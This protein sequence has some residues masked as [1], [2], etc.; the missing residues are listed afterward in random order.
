M[1]RSVIFADVSLLLV[2][3]VWGTTFVLVQNA[4]AFLEPFS[5][6]GVRFLMAAFLL[7]GW[8]VIFEREQLKKINKKLLI[9]GIIMGLF[10]F[11]GYAFQTIGLLHTTSSKAGFIT[12]L[13]V[14]MVPVFSFMLLKIKPGFNAIIGVSIA[15]AGLY[16]LTMTD[17]V[18]LNI[19]DAYV[20]ICAV[21][22]AL[23]IIFTGKYSSKYP[24]LL[25][26]VIQ[27]GTVALLSGIFAFFTENWQQAFETG[28]LFKTNVVT[29]LIVTSLFATALAFFAQTA[30]QKF[31]TPTRV[32]LIFAME[33]VFA[34]AAGFMWANERLSFS[35]LTGCLLIFAG[36][37]FA[38]IPAKKTLSIF[39]R[40]TA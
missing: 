26:T 33:P 24:A 25:L 30:F 4:I 39:R 6:N 36:M 10:L 12:G 15:T 3:F 9:S 32:A 14:V 11:I 35:A 19:G 1:N 7:G 16:L 22:F 21:G 17:K 27:V 20:L 37:V 40:K 29:A 13:S 2:A 23:H 18:S 5:F 28:V 34:A 38:E 8:L 31:T